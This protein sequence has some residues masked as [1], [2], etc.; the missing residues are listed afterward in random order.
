MDDLV[1]GYDDLEI[2][3]LRLSPRQHAEDHVELSISD[4][5]RQPVRIIL[6]AKLL[7]A[8][9]AHCAERALRPSF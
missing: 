6:P 3:E 8:Y 9:E 2:I 7:T 5:G 1:L 4:C